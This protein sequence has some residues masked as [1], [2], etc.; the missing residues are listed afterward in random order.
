MVAAAWQ[1]KASEAE[2]DCKLL[3]ERLAS[4]Q[5]TKNAIKAIQAKAK[6]NYKV[7]VRDGNKLVL[8]GQSK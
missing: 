8:I 6:V 2:R 4:C 5:I 3:S 7:F 1:S